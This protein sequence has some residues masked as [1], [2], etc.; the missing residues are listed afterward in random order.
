[1]QNKTTTTTTWNGLHLVN[2]KLLI[3]VIFQYEIIENGGEAIS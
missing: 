1:M 2:F 3:V